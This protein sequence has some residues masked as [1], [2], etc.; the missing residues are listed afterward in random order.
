MQGWGHSG[1]GLRIEFQN[2]GSAFKP[3]YM[4][5][6]L[7]VLLLVLLSLQIKLWFGEGGMRDVWR[8]EDSIAAQQVENE[9]LQERN[10]A[11]AAEVIDLKQGL[12][13]IEERARNEL[14]M[15]REGEVFYQVVEE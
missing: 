7:T 3:G 14:G 9:Q 4:K 12:E 1:S 10:R 8:L 6:I 11:L 2:P 15:I 13:A 5:I